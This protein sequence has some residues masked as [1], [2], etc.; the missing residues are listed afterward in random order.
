MPRS[1]LT[2]WIDGK[3]Y[4]LHRL[5][6]ETYLDRELTF[7][8]IVHHK[9]GD[10]HDNR[11]ENLEVMTRAEHK[12]QHDS[13]GKKTRFQKVFVFTKKELKKLREEGLS[14]YKIAKRYK[15]TQPTIW[16]VLKEYGIP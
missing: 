11:L 15:C 6:M 5:I 3:Q 13:I 4:R 9:N 8:E 14:G 2:K 1:Y 10:I 7:N 16:R 12:I